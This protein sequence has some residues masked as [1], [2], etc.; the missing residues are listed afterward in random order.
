[1]NMVEL[2]KSPSM[3]SSRPYCGTYRWENGF[4]SYFC[5]NGARGFH[6]SM[7]FTSA[8]ETTARPGLLRLTGSNGPASASLQ[9]GLTAGAVETAVATETVTSTPGS[10]V[11]SSAVIAGSV[12]GGVAAGLLLAVLAFLSTQWWRRRAR[13]VPQ[14]LEPKGYSNLGAHPDSSAPTA[15]LASPAIFS[16]SYGEHAPR[17]WRGQ[18]ELQAGGEVERQELP[19]K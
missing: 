13:P 7:Y 2:T 8:G 14:Q 12:V 9:T 15:A 18:Q 16:Q 19:A 11:P 4:T 6:S 5:H 10:N 1:M 3:T 17:A